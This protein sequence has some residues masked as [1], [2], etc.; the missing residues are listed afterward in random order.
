[1]NDAVH[2]PYEQDLPQVPANY[3]ALSPLSMIARAAAV[4][5]HRLAVV[6]GE[7]RFSWMERDGGTVGCTAGQIARIRSSAGA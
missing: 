1:M 6:H 7:R 5:P 4:Y 3:V 2:S